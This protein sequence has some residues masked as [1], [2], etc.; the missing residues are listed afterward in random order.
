M[1]PWTRLAVPLP[2]LLLAGCGT[3]APA[4]REPSPAATSPAPSPTPPPP[5]TRR[6]APR[7]KRPSRTPAPKPAPLHFGYSPKADAQAQI[8]AARRAARADGKQVLLD[9]GASWC[10]NCQAME[11]VFT[12]AQGRAVLTASYHLVQIDVDTNMRVL[13]RYDSAGSYGLPVLIILSPAGKIRVDTHK[14]G[15]PRFDQS[16]FLSFLRRWAG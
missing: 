12:S 11:A 7:V 14:S 10:G 15:N 3:A 4:A 6:P 13:T 1:K 2:A 5:A 16:G 9:F 8:D